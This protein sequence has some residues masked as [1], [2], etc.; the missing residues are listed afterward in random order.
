MKQTKTTTAHREKM[1][2]ARKKSGWRLSTDAE[3]IQEEMMEQGYRSVI[4][5]LFTATNDASDDL[6]EIAK[7]FGITSPEYNAAFQNFKDIAR[8]SSPFFV[9]EKAKKIEI[10]RDVESELLDILKNKRGEE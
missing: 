10:E 5:I 7:K 1:R 8:T 6:T 9:K 4:E 3:K 2:D